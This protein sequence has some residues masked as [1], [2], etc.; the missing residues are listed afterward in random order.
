M[1]KNILLSIVAMI[2]TIGTLN[3]QDTLDRP[4]YYLYQQDGDT[5]EWNL[6]VPHHFTQQSFAGKEFIA[7]Q[8]STIYGIAATYGVSTSGV[9]FDSVTW[10][11]LVYALLLQ[12]DGD[13]YVRVDSVHRMFDITPDHYY[14]YRLTYR[15]YVVNCD[16]ENPELYFAPLYEFYFR[17]PHVVHDTFYLGFKSYHKDHG[18]NYDPDKPLPR[19]ELVFI[20]TYSLDSCDVETCWWLDRH[21]N[22]P[23]SH[24]LAWRRQSG[25]R[26][27]I[28]GILTPPD[29]DQ[30]A[31]CLVVDGFGLQRYYNHTPVFQW[32]DTT[33]RDYQI[34]YGPAGVP[35]DSCHVVPCNGWPYR[36]TDNTLD[37]TIL[38]HAY[39]RQKCQHTC[40]V[41]DTSYWNAWSQPVSFYTGSQ[42]PDTGHTA[43]YTPQSL[44]FSLTPNPA[45][46]RVSVSAEEGGPYQVALHDE[47]G[48]Q[49]V[50]FT[51]QES[52]F[53]LNISAFPSG[54]YYLTIRSGQRVGTQKIVKQ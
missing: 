31:E 19:C 13:Q 52:V 46:D 4:A 53:T 25:A 23:E 7:V 26:N 5:V 17:T 28:F 16:K 30:V 8:P 44:A 42:A 36:I 33:T 11:M 22:Y 10:N 1:T 34:A 6:S 47:S 20:G 54:I 40:W 49:L 21:I 35:P 18:A 12:K 39:I 3:A 41:H 15:D 37:S 32:T 24:I 45:H 50:S 43:I 38:Y 2:C 9:S 48:R 14:I 29:T 27:S 51:I